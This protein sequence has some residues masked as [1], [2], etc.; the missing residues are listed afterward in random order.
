MHL[1]YRKNHGRLVEK[2]TFL[3]IISRNASDD[4]SGSLEEAIEL[5]RASV[6]FTESLIDRLWRKGVLNKQDVQNM[7]KDIENVHPNA[8]I[9]IEI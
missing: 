5:S 1:T 8:E 4:S 9:K 3:E 2:K 7:L 6:R